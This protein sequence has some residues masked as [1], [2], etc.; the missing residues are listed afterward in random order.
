M[1][2]VMMLLSLLLAPA[3]VGCGDEETPPAPSLPDSG[4][5]PTT[6]VPDAGAPDSGPSIPLQ[7]WVRAMVTEGGDDGNGMADTVDDKIGIVKDTDDPAAF[8]E[9]LPPAP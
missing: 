2:R 8:D 6:P 3:L 9:L 1:K 4:T 7:N 5:P